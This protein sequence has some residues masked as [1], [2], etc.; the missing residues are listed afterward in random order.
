MNPQ[1]E[2]PPRGRK[3]PDRSETPVSFLPEGNPRARTAYI[4]ALIGLIPG[5]GLFF[6]PP[7]FI[8]GRL[9]YAT[10]KKDLETKGI[11]HAYASMILGIAETVLSAVG[12]ALIARGLEWI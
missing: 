12:L 9:G 10:A 1:S 11:G 8:L 3:R 2:G 5:L 4:C 6:G 7:A